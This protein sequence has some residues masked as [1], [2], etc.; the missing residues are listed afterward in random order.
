MQIRDQNDLQ[1][2]TQSNSEII[3]CQQYDLDDCEQA[4]NYTVATHPNLNPKVRIMSFRLGV[5]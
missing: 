4:I 5:K 1:D 3:C 2:N